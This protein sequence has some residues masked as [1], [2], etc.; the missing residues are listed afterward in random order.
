[1]GQAL[2]EIRNWT[3][4]DPVSRM[5]GDLFEASVIRDYPVGDS[6]R[7]E[8]ERAK[9]NLIP[10]GYKDT[11]AGDLLIWKTVLAIGKEG[12]DVIFVC[13]DTK[14][15]WRHHAKSGPLYP[16]Y[17]LVDEFRRAS[18]GRTLHII[19]LSEL[20]HLFEAAKGAIHEVEQAELRAA[21]KMI[22]ER[23]K[24][25]G[26]TVGNFG[27][28]R[29]GIQGRWRQMPADLSEDAAKHF[30]GRIRERDEADYAALLPQIQAVREELAAAGIS[31]AE[32]DAFLAEFTDKVPTP[33]DAIAL[34]STFSVI[35]HRV[36][37]MASDHAA[38]GQQSRHA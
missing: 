2:V 7:D 30:R 17:E 33:S 22:V 29:M 6:I 28:T 15:D 18:N 9:K 26:I 32:L 12:K 27:Y 25:V 10:P 19:R 16:R 38:L 14:A 24:T 8:W 4:D 37:L 36:E 23:L 21:T 1:M 20:L 11:G 13:Q 5:Y 3:W 34:G 35:A 31:T